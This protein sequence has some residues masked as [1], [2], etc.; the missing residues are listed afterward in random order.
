MKDKFG[1]VLSLCGR[2]S[3]SNFSE[4]IFL[5]VHPFVYKVCAFYQS[6]LGETPWLAEKTQHEF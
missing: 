3:A 2:S 1:S 4:V 5:L 6:A